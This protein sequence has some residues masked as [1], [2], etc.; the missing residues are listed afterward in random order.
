MS[1]RFAVSFDLRVFLHLSF[2]RMQHSLLLLVW[3]LCGLMPSF[4]GWGAANDVP[5]R[6]EIQGRLDTL[7]KQK[8]LTSA[9]K[10]TQQDLI[11]T[12]DVLDSIERVKQE[13]TQLKQQA[14]QAPA[15]L[16]QVNED[17][18]ALSATPPVTP[19][20]LESLPLKQLEARLNETL[21]DL[22]AA[23]ENLSPI[24]AS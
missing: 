16:K 8:S 12:L 13:T 2:C 15:K 17:L 21:D 6:A 9:D 11:Q 20:A 5:T 4:S 24:T 1:C 3:A 23:Q 7:N 10:L 22:Q 18:L 14:A 19:P